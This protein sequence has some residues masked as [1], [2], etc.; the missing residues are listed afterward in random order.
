LC[1]FG[2]PYLSKEDAI[3]LI[4]DAASLLVPGGV[5]Y[6]ST[7]EGDYSSS[8]MQTS[9]SGDSLFMYYHEA[10]YLLEALKA[11]GFSI[12]DMRRIEFPPDGGLGNDLVIVARRSASV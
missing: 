4:G 11:C 9:S 12:V 5:L 2:L 7:M 3:K 1:G 10:G 8:G 6:L